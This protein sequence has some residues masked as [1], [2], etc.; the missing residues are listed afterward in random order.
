MSASWGR[1]QIMGANHVNAG[2]ATVQQFVT[3]HRASESNHLD[4]HKI[5]TRIQLA[6]DV[7]DGVRSIGSKRHSDLVPVR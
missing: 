2:Y 6:P 5:N 7:D 4:E 3:A 1:F